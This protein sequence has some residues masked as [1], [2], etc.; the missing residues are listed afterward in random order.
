MA[1]N[2]VVDEELD[3]RITFP[4][5][6]GKDYSDEEGQ[7][8]DQ[9]GQESSEPVVILLGWLGCQEKHLAKYASIWEQKRLD[10][11]SLLVKQ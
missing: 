4:S 2:E 5:P 3:Y 9:D 7:D 8:A 1:E 10:T 6:V 11:E